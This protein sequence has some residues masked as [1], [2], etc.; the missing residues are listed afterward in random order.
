M[1][2]ELG[3][4]CRDDLRRSAAEGCRRPSARG[5]L[6]VGERSLPGDE[7][8]ADAEEWQR[9]LREHGKGGDRPCRHEIVS[10]ATG[11]VPAEV[12]GPGI[13]HTD[14]REPERRD[15]PAE[16]LG[17]LADRVDEGPGHGRARE[18]ED[19]PGHATAGPEVEG[20]DRGK[21]VDDTGM[22]DRSDVDGPFTG[23][24]ELGKKLAGSK[25]VNDCM[26]TQW[27]RFASGRAE[28]DRDAC[29]VSTL[30]DALN[31]SGGDMRELFVAYTQTDAFLFRSKGDQ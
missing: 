17:L 28:T 30:Q 27:F 4:A 14:V 23:V 6:G 19:H 20:T 31:R 2:A 22:L 1:I 9:V 21:P 15:E 26:A 7:R 16:R 18:G 3:E 25:M 8:P 11:R 29:S 5:Q 12:L 10:L 24:V 13:A